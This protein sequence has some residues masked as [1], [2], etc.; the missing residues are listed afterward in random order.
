VVDRTLSHYRVVERLGTGGMGEVYRAR[1]E[2]LDRDVALKVLPDGALADEA[3][4]SRF[5]REAHALSRLSHPHV[6]TLLDFDSDD[7]VDFLVMELVGG[8]S[9]EESLRAGPLGE[10]DVVRLGAQL[11]RGLQA[12]HEQGVV[13]R[14]LKP[15]NL[16][17]TPDGLLKILDFGLARLLPPIPRRAGEST[18][19][20]SAAGALAGSPPYMA[21]EQLLGKPTDA[22]T[23]IYG[24]GAVLYELA[25]ANRPFGR[26]TGVALTD[27]ILHEP[28]PPPRSLVPSVSAG[29]EAV[30]LKALDKDPGLRHQTAKDLLVDLERLGAAATAEASS[31]P[32]TVTRPWRRWPWLVV[33][34]A[35][36]AM[37]IGAWYLRPLPP[38]RITS[39]RPLRLEPGWYGPGGLAFTWA[40][41]G[42]RLYYVALERG[43]FRL[44]QV[45]A[46]GGEP[47]EIAL[48]LP[49][50]RGFEIY[51]FLRGPSALL[52][53]AVPATSPD[54]WPVYL[55]PVPH[56]TPSRLGELTANTAAVSPD[57]RQIVLRDFVERRLVLAQAD[58]SRPR[59][60]TAVPG[61]PGDWGHVEWS[62]DGRRIRFGARGKGQTETWIWETSA[63]GDTPRPLWPGWRGAWTADGRYY[64]FEH[65]SATA[66]R[67]DLFWV[68]EASWPPWHRP[69]PEP[70]TTGPLNFSAVGPRPGGGGLI[71]VGTDRRGELLRFDAVKRQ[72]VQHLGGPS[73]YSVDYSRDGQ[74]LAWTTWPEGTLWR[75]R[76]D[77]SEKLQ[78]TPTG[79]WA[80]LPR[81]SPDGKHIAF[82][83]EASAG[84]PKTISL[85]SAAGGAAEGLVPAEPGLDTWDVCWL[86]DGHTLVYSYLQFERRGLFRVDTGTRRIS[87]WPGAER[88]AFPKCSAEGRIFALERVPSRS[89]SSRD[90]RIFLPERGTWEPVVVP[91]F[92]YANWTRDGQALLG[93]N[94]EAGRIER[95]SLLSHRSEALVD[96]PG[97]P[98]VSQEAAAWMGVDATDAP[99]VT[100]DATTVDL[101]TIDWA[102]P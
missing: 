58:G 86:P 43:S 9:L 22:R 48:P 24:A 84:A 69:R 33:G 60:L 21:P 74:W 56:G 47:T 94:P 97:V 49:F 31:S 42:V 36:S 27:A 1:D 15:S 51:G 8:P 52:C 66:K 40:T 62:P 78:L 63:T 90:S 12:A 57:G 88:L 5:R 23:D 80:G 16:H 100:R 87:P 11:A 92:V 41:D 89:A 2:R 75:S 73:A 10:K 67:S 70:L 50:G 29:L 61:Q 38:P 45:P 6:A 4:R 76:A 44:M 91:G 13:H 7:G 77:G 71:A 93:F 102:A 53:L 25:T 101:Y 98:L 59:V 26:R 81:W 72:F 35:V 65:W 3:A 99:L 79:V 30:I 32:M 17:C 19:S 34:A 85:V 64:V 37:A 18:A 68:R 96:R 54:R 82:T 95:F 39:V 46:T 83:G 20:E 14:D 28:P 55:V